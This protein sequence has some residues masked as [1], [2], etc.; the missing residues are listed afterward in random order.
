MSLPGPEPLACSTSR[1]TFFAGQA[2]PEDSGVRIVVALMAFHLT[3]SDQQWLS[4]VKSTE[5]ILGSF[6]QFASSYHL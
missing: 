2:V 1:S 4:A 3:V 5:W 6:L